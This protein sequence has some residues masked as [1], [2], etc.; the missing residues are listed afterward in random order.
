VPR[1][2]NRGTKSTAAGFPEGEFEIIMTL[3]ITMPESRRCRLRA[4][5]CRAIAGRLR[6]QN[7][8]VQMLK[9]AANYD[10]MASDAELRE[11]AQGLR[12]LRALA[13]RRQIGRQVA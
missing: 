2:L 4:L 3:A 10:R 6:M 5:E 9:V 13:A 8:R 1:F 11:I 12:H 7:A